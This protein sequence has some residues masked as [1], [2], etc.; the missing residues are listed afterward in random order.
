MPQTL[1]ISDLHLDPSKPELSQLFQ[2]FLNQTA[3]H[4]DALYILGDFFDTWLGD[5]D[6]SPFAET[7]CQ[8]LL[9]FSEHTPLYL[10]PGNHDFLYGHKF[11]QRTRITLIP[12]PSLLNI[13]GFRLLALHGDS[14]CICDTKH[15]KSRKYMHNSFIK[16]CCYCLPL[17]LRKKIAITLTNNHQT[18]YSSEKKK[19]LTHIPE[20]LVI[21]T[22]QQQQTTTMIHGHTHQP[23]IHK[24]SQNDC[25]V[26]RVVLGNW[27]QTNGWYAELNNQGILSLN[28]F[29]NTLTNIDSQSIQLQHT[30]IPA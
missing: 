26:H 17:G 28:K 20:K 10:M 25:N 5:D 4:A 18:S 21:D 13:Y 22:C 8:T 23:H 7:I 14:L 30:A 15:Q 2:D 9:Q 27:T 19:I 11:Q 1:F 29:N 3:S 24:I 12:D 16:K 6:Y